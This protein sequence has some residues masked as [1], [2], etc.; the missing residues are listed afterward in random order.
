MINSSEAIGIH[1]ELVTR[2]WTLVLCSGPYQ[3]ARATIA[4]HLSMQV[5]PPSSST[6][7]NSST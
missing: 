5:S 3:G 7:L 6:T 1:Q 2:K 4:E